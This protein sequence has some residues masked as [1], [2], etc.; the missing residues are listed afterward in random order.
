MDPPHRKVAFIQLVEETDPVGVTSEGIMVLYEGSHD[1][2]APVELAVRTGY[3]APESA[4]AMHRLRRMGFIIPDN[5]LDA[6][7]NIYI[8][9]D[10]VDAIEATTIEGNQ[11]S[12]TPRTRALNRVRWRTMQLEWALTTDG[13]EPSARYL[14]NLSQASLE[15]STLPSTR[16]D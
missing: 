9:G 8:N 10:E 6:A 2:E 4:L 1:D 12:H 5:E 3:V 15:Y 16:T 7:M 11:V 13:L 14:W